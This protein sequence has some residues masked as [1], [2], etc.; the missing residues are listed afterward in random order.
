ML[1]VSIFLSLFTLL[2][3]SMGVFYLAKLIK[4]PY[5]VLLVL[6]GVLMIPVSTLPFLSFLS[7]FKLTADLLFLYFYL[8]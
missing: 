1:S 3:I 6:V 8:L 5:T 2:F 7:E 4:I